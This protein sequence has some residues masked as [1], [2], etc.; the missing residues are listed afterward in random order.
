MGGTVEDGS[1]LELLRH[2]VAELRDKLR[3]TERDRDRLAD[4]LAKLRRT[5]FGR[6]SERFLDHPMLPFEGDEQEPTK[7]PHVDEAPDDEEGAAKPK[8][9]RTR[10]ANRLPADLPRERIELTLPESELRCACCGKPK[11]K[12]GE[13]VTEELEYR[14]GSFFIREIVRPKFACGD[15]EEGGV[16]TPELPPRVV[17]KGLPGSGLL[18]HV[19]TSK[20]RDHLPLH[21]QHGIFLRHGV[22]IPETSMVDWVSAGARLLVP[23]V[24]V[25][26]REVLASFAIHTDDTSLLV[27]DR[28]HK[29]GSRR[30]FLW[31]YIGDR[32]DV[33]F[34]FTAGRTRDGPRAFLDG[35]QGYLHADAYTGYDAL[36]R[37]GIVEVGCWSHA[38]RM[39]VDALSKFPE[40]AG[41][42]VAVIRR[43][44]MIERE[45]ADF[46]PGARRALRLQESKPLLDQ[47]GEY[48]RHLRYAP[49]VLPEGPLGK[50]ITYCLNQWDALNRFLDD[51]RLAI[52]NN[53]AERG[54][55][56]VVVGRKNW[57]FAGSDEGARRAATIY[58]VIVS[59]TMLELDPFEYL[60]DVLLR[61]A[62]GEDPAGLTP[63]A[64][65]A[66][67]LGRNG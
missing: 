37:S 20:Y 3:Q 49:H 52:H 25:M 58:S 62:A 26:R 1:E 30:G 34:D 6:R 5:L 11:Q 17:A 51:G 13:V 7:P 38:R 45:A 53:V 48:L 50:A 57:L 15:H 39:F 66:A 33:V 44:F 21:R 31:I 4:L 43:L 47:L 32:S 27:Q 8:G 9:K 23:V 10:R 63:R 40:E 36:Y 59:C 29:G 16:A 61:L 28:H 35:F 64:W 65:K 54:L 46:D 60:R 56:Q 18:A 22:D 41:A 24:D 12:I 2:E 14:P 55:R 19:L 42:V 67:R